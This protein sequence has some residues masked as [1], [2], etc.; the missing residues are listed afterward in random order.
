MAISNCLNIKT[1]FDGKQD[2][3][4]KYK[5]FKNISDLQM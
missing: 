5:S 1:L 4:V 3:D 2:D